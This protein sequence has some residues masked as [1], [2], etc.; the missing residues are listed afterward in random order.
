MNAKLVGASQAEV[1]QAGLLLAGVAGR[2]SEE[3]WDDDPDWEQVKLLL[4][5]AEKALYELERTLS[6][7][8]E[9]ENA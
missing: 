9:S 6:W 5:R 3:L 7:N 1:R 8:Q 2:L 4:W